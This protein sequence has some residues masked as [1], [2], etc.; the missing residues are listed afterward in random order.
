MKFK[1]FLTILA[2]FGL[3]VP[4]FFYP[5][6][7]GGVFLISGVSYVLLIFTDV[8]P[9]RKSLWW[10]SIFE[11]L[12]FILGGDVII[13]SIL[14]RGAFCFEGD[15]GFDGDILNSCFW[16][17][18]EDAIDWRGESCFGTCVKNVQ[19]EDINLFFE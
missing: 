18:S 11:H 5:Y 16:L 9:P 14:P 15:W 17:G 13:F 10:W 12:G 2:A 8:L 3:L 19:S 7:K 6:L 1:K 4:W